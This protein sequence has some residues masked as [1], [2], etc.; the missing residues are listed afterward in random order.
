MNREQPSPGEHAAESSSEDA[1]PSETWSAALVSLAVIVPP[2]AAVLSISLYVLPWP[3]GASWPGNVAVLVAI[4]VTL[5]AWAGA[6]AVLQGSCSAQRADPDAYGTLLTRLEALE[7]QTGLSGAAAPPPSVHDETTHAAWREVV[8]CD[9]AIHQAFGK[10]GMPWILGTGYVQMWMVLHNLEEAWIELEP[11]TSL[12]RDAVLD[13][14]RLMGST[15]DNRDDLLDQLRLAVQQLGSDAARYLAKLP[16]VPVPC[17]PPAAATPPSEAGAAT[18]PSEAGAASASTTSATPP[19]GETQARAILRSVR[20]AIN[21]YRD[22]RRGGLIRARNQLMATVFV[23]GI[24]V[25]LLL[26][27]ALVQHAPNTAIVGAAACFLVG[28][29]VGLFNRLS[30]QSASDNA[31]DDFGLSVARLTLTP[32]FS[33]LAAV[34]GVLLAATV[35]STVLGSLGAPPVSSPKSLSLQDIYNLGRDPFNVVVA[36]VFGLTPSLFL[37]GIQQQGD[38]LKADLKSSQASSRGP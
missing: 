2:V 23:T 17:P 7:A 38:R 14:A 21:E 29:G 1:Q 16:A 28:A 32:V 33:G 8:R 37:A 15:L 18:L 13:E 31:V 30:A 27:I 26:A 12:I 10:P 5:L 22:T 6:A 25:Y 4:L 35:F 3:K 9:R 34:G 20:H 36:A 11:W 19:V 24:T